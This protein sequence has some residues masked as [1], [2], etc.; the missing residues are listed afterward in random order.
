MASAITSA[1]AAAA[2]AAA[3]LPEPR[4]RA[5]RRHAAAHRTG[6]HLAERHLGRE[7][8]GQRGQVDDAELAHEPAIGNADQALHRHIQH[9]GSSQ[10]QDGGHDRP[11]QH[12]LPALSG[13]HGRVGSMR[14]ESRARAY[15][16]IP[17]FGP[18]ASARSPGN[19]RRGSMPGVQRQ[20]GLRQLAD[21]G[22]PPDI[23]RGGDVE[24]VFRDP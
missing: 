14:A 22:S 8:E 3:R 1:W 10:G 19:S 15:L 21:G 4:A 23:H 5:E 24:M 6:R 17:S 18:Q 7:D 20:D 13:T 16:M 11:G 12:H 9:V 2:S